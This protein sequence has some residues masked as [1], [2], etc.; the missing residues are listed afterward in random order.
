M[1]DREVTS[2]V[3]LEFLAA[4]GDFEDSFLHEDGIEYEEEADKDLIEKRFKTEVVDSYGGED[5]GSTYYTVWKITDRETNESTFL[6][7]HG[8]Y[9]SHYGTDYNGVKEV[10]PKTKTVIEYD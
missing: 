3:G 4:V 9:A 2:K 5:Q 1:S 7:F 6:K 8:W 10:T